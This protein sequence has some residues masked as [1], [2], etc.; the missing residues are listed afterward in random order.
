MLAGVMMIGE[1]MF[2]TL[3]EGCRP[4]P[5]CKRKVCKECLSC[6][7]SLCCLYE[8]SAAPL[9]LPSLSELVFYAQRTSGQQ[10]VQAQSCLINGHWQL[11]QLVLSCMHVGSSAV[12]RVQGDRVSRKLVAATMRSLLHV[13]LC[14]EAMKNVLYH[15]IQQSGEVYHE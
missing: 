11:K 3:A 8:G 6:C 14:W 1:Q 12:S 13:R 10:D 7:C 2:C 15:C 5:I 4:C 9:C